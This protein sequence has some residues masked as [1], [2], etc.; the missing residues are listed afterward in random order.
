VS[1]SS[2]ARRKGRLWAIGDIHGCSGALRALLEAIDPHPEDTIVTLGDTIDW[3]PDSRGVI[4]LLIDL[5]GRCNLIPLLGNHEEMLLD[6]LESGPALR[7]WLDLGGE[8]TLNSYDYDGGGDM[9][10]PEHLRFIR[11]CRDYYETET[12]IYVHANYDPHLPMD[13]MSGTKLRWEPLDLTVLQPHISGKTVVV[14]HTPQVGGE[15]LDLGFLVCIDTDCSRGGWLTAFCGEVGMV[16][17][18]EIGLVRW[19]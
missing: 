10:P 18:S 4:D 5:S 11:S 9:I 8:E 3:G 12:H 19:M 15:V 14:G 13:R 7:G 16:Q 17:A 1:P 2:K 6:A